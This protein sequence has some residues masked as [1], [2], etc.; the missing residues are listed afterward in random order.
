MKN[1]YWLKR[2]LLKSIFFFLSFLH[3][4]SVSRSN[5]LQIRTRTKL[6][7]KIKRSTTCY[8][9][10]Y[11]FHCR[12]RFVFAWPTSSREKRKMKN[13]Q[14]TN[15]YF[16][17]WVRDTNNNL[18]WVYLSFSDRTSVHRSSNKLQIFGIR[19]QLTMNPVKACIITFLLALIRFIFGSK[20]KVVCFLILAGSS[21]FIKPITR[22]SASSLNKPF[23]KI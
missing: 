15:F 3:T 12:L 2:T 23:H 4:S 22:S 17:L 18:K 7:G 16:F 21:T 8:R 20:R 6:F 1:R 19:N 11:V 13:F 10:L 5:K 14:I 9:F